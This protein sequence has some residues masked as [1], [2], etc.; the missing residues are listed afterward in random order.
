MDERE[1]SI[2][3]LGEALESCS[4]QPLTGFWRNGCCDTGPADRG[5]H[6]V[7]AVMTAEFL[8][9]SKYLG[10]DL[11]TPRP[12]FGFAGLKPGD[13]WCLC[14]ARFLQAHEEGAAPQLRLRATHRRTL[15]IVPL[16][17]LRLYA[18]D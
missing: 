4:T 8:A 14:A 10:N 6:T 11:S 3:V 16:E 5:R 12:E 2:N 9:L 1:D 18:A 7:C 13:N 15:D 17:V